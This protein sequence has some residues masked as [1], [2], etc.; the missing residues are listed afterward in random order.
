MA[1]ETTFAIEDLKG[2]QLLE[3]WQPFEV[4][5]YSDKIYCL[6]VMPKRNFI[7]QNKNP[8]Y[9]FVYCY[10]YLKIKAIAA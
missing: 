9:S 7:L 2:C 5:V 4:E 3:S 10:Q 8:G 1:G 6:T